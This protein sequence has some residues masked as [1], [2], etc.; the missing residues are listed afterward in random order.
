MARALAPVL[1][2]ILLLSAAWPV[3]AETAPPDPAAVDAS[4]SC[5]HSAGLSY[6]AFVT[7][8]GARGAMLV[9]YPTPATEVPQSRGPARFVAALDARPVEGPLGIVLLSHGFGGHPLAHHAT[10][11]HL[12]RCGWVVAAVEHPGT[13]LRGRGDLGTA[14]AWTARPR[15]LSRALDA[16]LADPRF[17]D[18]LDPGRVAVLGHGAGG[19]TALLLA[20][21]V[22]DLR[23]LGAHCAA[24]P[25]DGLCRTSDRQGHDAAAR[26]LADPRVGAVVLLAPLG[27]FFAEAD[28]AR[29]RVP[30]MLVA[31]GRDREAP[32]TVHA[33][34]IAARLPLETA[35]EAAPEAGHFSFLAPLPADAVEVAGEIWAPLAADPPGFDRAAFQRRLNARIAAFLARALP[36]SRR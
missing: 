19:A 26:D 23:R 7:D 5:P 24:H 28:L 36:P 8:A 15:H 29:V 6:G 14:R 32:P 22:A 21:A 27:A 3:A 16:L 10:A 2:C 30:V 25:G 1:S 20:G 17:A 35:A 13:S 31:G 11:A 18:R 4:P 9:W 34:R 12:A 33:E